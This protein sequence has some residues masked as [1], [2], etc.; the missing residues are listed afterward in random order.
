VI[1][2]TMKVL[3][4]I[5]AVIKACGTYRWLYDLLRPHGTIRLAHPMDMKRGL[6]L[7]NCRKKKGE[8]KGG[9]NYFPPSCPMPPT[10]VW[11]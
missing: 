8:K 6:I 5:C 1:E 7:A 4:P 2:S 11:L 10:T 3:R 9:Q